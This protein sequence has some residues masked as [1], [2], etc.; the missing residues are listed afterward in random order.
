MRST[1]TAAVVLAAV[2]LVGGISGCSGLGGSSDD[3]SGGGGSG[4]R[5]ANSVGRGTTTVDT[6]DKVVAKGTFDSPMAPG[7][8][9]DIAINRLKVDGRL[10]TLTAQFTPHVPN[11]PL[12]PTLYRLNGEN[13]L[14]PALVDPVNLKR[15]IVVKDARGHELQTDEISTNLGNEQ[16]TQVHFTFAAP[17]ENVKSVNVQLGTWPT[18]RAVPVER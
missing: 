9:V 8:K 14:D 13:G 11:P 4:A 5:A 15:Y 10:A 2:L 12:K 1:R 16:P 7:A 3:S 18:F 17:P 6:A